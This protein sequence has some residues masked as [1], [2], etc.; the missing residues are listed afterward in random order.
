MLLLLL[1]HR[2]WRLIDASQGGGRWQELL[3]QLPGDCR[4][5]MLLLLRIHV[6]RR[7]WGAVKGGVGRARSGVIVG[8]RLQ[9]V[10]LAQTASVGTAV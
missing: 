1:L 8:S 5:G 3:D 10:L 6:S 7:R 4:C 2:L 9:R